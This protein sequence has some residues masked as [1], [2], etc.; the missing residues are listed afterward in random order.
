VLL[1]GWHFLHSSPSTP[2]AQPITTLPNLP[3]A[4]G[5]PAHLTKPSAAAGVA[6]APT[7]QS[8]RQTAKASHPAAVATPDGKP[9][10]RVVAFTYNR[11]DQA[12]Q[13][14]AAL[15]R[16]HSFL[17]PEVFSPTGKAPYLVT[18][19]G[20]MTREQAMAFREKARNAGLPRD[21]YAQNYSG[22]PH[23]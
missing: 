17:R 7:R 22:N 21:T 19:G 13:K 1:L 16:D 6:N 12:W 11:E 15:T 18:V 20:S 14:A 4:S 8:L 5:A 9:Q 3:A 23:N 2:P 10:W